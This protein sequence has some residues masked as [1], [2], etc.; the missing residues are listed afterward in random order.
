MSAAP[1]TMS[2]SRSS[3]QGD[4][5]QQEKIPDLNLAQWTFLLGRPE[6]DSKLKNEI[7]KNLMVEIEK[8]DM[9]HFYREAAACVGNLYIFISF[10]DKSYDVARHVEIKLGLEN[11][12]TNKNRKVRVMNIFVEHANIPL[13]QALLNRM[14]EKNKQKLNELNDAIKD[15]EENLGE[16]EVRDA[17]F[18][19]A[20]FLCRI[21]DK[22]NAISALK[23]TYEKTIGV[24]RKIDLVFFMIRIGLFYSDH[25]LITT[26]LAKAKYLMEQKKQPDVSIL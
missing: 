13:D 5:N 12:W 11:L 25:Q 3:T 17:N 22:S 14:E 23:K 9:S 18:N 19:K 7:L 2:D 6:Y 8:Y 15:A 26:H 24:G 21:G 1:V 16:T 4:E 20:V 10:L